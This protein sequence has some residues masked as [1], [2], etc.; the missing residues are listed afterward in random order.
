VCLWP[1]MIWITASVSL[2]CQIASLARYAG[3]LC[4]P[5]DVDSF[6]VEGSSSAR[7]WSDGDVVDEGHEDGALLVDG[8]TGPCFA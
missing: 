5:S 1:R 2:R 6:G 8:E 7:C 4:G 3:G